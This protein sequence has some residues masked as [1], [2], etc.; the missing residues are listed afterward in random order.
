LKNLSELPKNQ[1]FVENKSL[2]NSNNIFSF[3]FTL[4]YFFRR[5]TPKYLKECRA[6]ETADKAPS[7]YKQEPRLSGSYR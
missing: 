7:K 4:E 3:L 6:N 5:F 1:G 2:I